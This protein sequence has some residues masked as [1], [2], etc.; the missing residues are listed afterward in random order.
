MKTN[1]KLFKYIIGTLALTTLF[2]LP[3]SLILT[4]CSKNDS[5]QI[6]YDKNVSELVNSYRNQLNTYIK[7]DSNYYIY[8][9]DKV[10]GLLKICDDNLLKAYQIK[11]N[12]W[13]LL[14]I[15]G[16]IWLDSLNNRGQNIITTIPT[17]NPDIKNPKDFYIVAHYD[18]TA[19]G[20]N[21]SSWGA[22]VN[23]FDITLF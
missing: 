5:D 6:N 16:Q 22:I 10:P 20:T 15:D 13:D 19:S 4:S 11:N 7:G 17:T 14:S 3:T 2:V 12:N 21:K 23:I 1:K 9:D 18:S 8:N